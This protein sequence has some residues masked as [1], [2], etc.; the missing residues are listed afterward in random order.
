[1]TLPFV[2][3]QFISEDFGRKTQVFLDDDDDVFGN[4]ELLLELNYR[5]NPITLIKTPLGKIKKFN[6][7]TFA[8]STL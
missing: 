8:I 3:N 6:S 7:V 1:M 4:N 5:I 2:S